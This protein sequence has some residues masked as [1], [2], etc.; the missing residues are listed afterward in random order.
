VR[1]ASSGTTTGFYFVATGLAEVV[2]KYVPTP[3]VAFY[4]FT[5]ASTSL[6]K[7]KT[8]KRCAP[9]GIW[10]SRE[11]EAMTRSSFPRSI[12]LQE[13][14]VSLLAGLLIAPAA[15]ASDVGPGFD[16]FETV[17]GQTFQDFSGTPIPAGFFDPGSEPF[18]E[19]VH[20]KGMPL[21]PSLGT[22]D[23]LVVRKAIAPL[24]PPLPA[25]DTV[26]IELVALSLTSVA[27]ITVT[28]DQG[29]PQKWN[30]WVFPSPSASTDGQITIHHTDD[31]G[32]AFYSLLPV[33]P[34][35]VFVR[36]RDQAVRI[37]DGG[38]LGL[39]IPFVAADVP[40]CHKANPAVLEVPTLN[41]GFFPGVHCP[42]TGAGGGKRLTREQAAQAA[43][44]ILPAQGHFPLGIVRSL[45]QERDLVLTALR[46]Y[47]AGLERSTYTLAGAGGLFTMEFQVELLGGQG[48]TCG[49]L[50]VTIGAQ[51]DFRFRAMPGPCAVEPDSQPPAVV[52]AQPPDGAKVVEG[53]TLLVRV[54]ATDDVQVTKVQLFVAFGQEQQV[55]TDFESP[56]DFMINVLEGAAGQALRFRAQ[57]EDK[58]GN[59][60]MSEPVGVQIVED[61]P[62]QVVILDPPEN[63]VVFERQ[64]V[65]VVAS[66]VDDVGALGGGIRSVEFYVN[67]R[68]VFVDFEPDPFSD[69]IY[70]VTF[71]VRAGTA[72]TTLT[73]QARASDT[74]GQMTFS[75][76]R[77]IVV[78]EDG[79]A[80]RGG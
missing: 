29:P 14:V 21:N 13:A 67:G 33:T 68:L 65:E 17:S 32:G 78:G 40:W 74:S 16:L 15:L 27:P 70:R 71:V 77:L 54:D 22:T 53:A 25:S 55:L 47:I 51:G 76:P 56:Y 39:T 1:I 80:G 46:N 62:P 9:A 30:V 11:E 63:S 38:P 35:F 44:G 10:G 36:P 28:L 43:H 5:C 20:F 45:E 12:G 4:A 50:A 7:H 2:E 41:S 69:G 8:H 48:T 24:P 49:D 72:G 57:A 37:L 18:T 59:V 61:G 52:I 58:S 64:T 66:A 73:L 34:L 60:G 75:V 26:P 79:S 42:P 31:R 6:S 3:D 19:T 23:T